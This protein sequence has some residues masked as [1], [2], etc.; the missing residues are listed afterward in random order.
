MIKWYCKRRFLNQYFCQITLLISLSLLLLGC[1]VRNNLQT[2]RALAIEF[3]G[4]MIAPPPIGLGYEIKAIIAESN[5][6]RVNP[7][8]DQMLSL[9]PAEIIDVVKS[10]PRGFFR[11]QEYARWEYFIG[12]IDRALVFSDAAIQNS[13]GFYTRSECLFDQVIF[14]AASGDYFAA[15]AALQ[16]AEETIQA[17]LLH[18]PPFDEKFTIRRSYL[19]ALSKAS[20]Q[21][22]QG[23]MKQAEK[24]YFEA[25]EHLTQLRQVKTV[26][27]P[28]IF[29]FF[30]RSDHLVAHIHIGIAN[31]L[32]WQGRL[33]EA[34]IW[35]R[36]SIVYHGR[37]MLP[38]IFITLSRIF[39][40]Q[41]QFE[42]SETLALSA[43]DMFQNNFPGL[44]CVP[45]DSLAR[46][47]SRG[48]LA[49]T[50]L[51]QGRYAEALAQFELI[52]ME[53]ATN[54]ETFE[55]IFGGNL[56]WGL[57]LLMSGQVDA[58]KAQLQR[59][60]E[61]A[62]YRFGP[63]DYA[64]MEARA[65]LAVA[66]AAAGDTGNARAA[67]DT[68]FNRLVSSQGDQPAA[69]VGYFSRQRRLEIIAEGYIA[70]LTRDNDSESAAKAFAI[71]GRCLSRSVGTTLAATSARSASED[72][73]LTG[74]I[75]Q[76]QDLDMAL[77]A[78]RSRIAE[79]MNLKSGTGKTDRLQKIL[80]ELK[81]RGGAL[82]RAIA[83]LDQEIR[84][85]F[86]EYSQMVRP[87]TANIEHIRKVMR[88][89]EAFV[90]VFTGENATF[91]WS[92]QK[93]SPVRFAKVWIGARELNRYVYD[94]RK[95][96]DPGS[97]ARVK[98]I[99]VFDTT[100]ANRLFDLLLAPV[101][102][103][104]EKSKILLVVANA[105][106]DRLPLSVLV[107]DSTAPESRNNRL[108]LSDYQRIPWLIRTH[109]VATLPSVG[110]IV[111]LR[112]RPSLKSRK[113]T[114]AG[115]GDPWFSRDQKT[116]S[117]KTTSS[118]A[119][120]GFH[121][122]SVPKRHDVDVISASLPMLPRL[123]ETADEVREIAVSLGA[124][125]EKDVFSGPAA[126]EAQIKTMDLSDRRILVFATHGLMPGD[127]DGLHQPAL[128]MS[129]PAYS[130]DNDSDGL[131]TMGEI[132]WLNLNAD[133][134]V[135]SACNTASPNG[136]G[137]EAM[138]GLGQA[139]FYAG[140]RSMLVTNWPVETNSAKTLTTALFQRL[141][142]HP[143]IH[144]AKALQMSQTALID[145]PG[146]G[147]Y[148]Y[149]HPLFWAP[150]TFVG[151]GNY[152]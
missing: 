109:A 138:S 131:L 136:R 30:S 62:A 37:F 2:A 85:Q 63:Y 134:V 43:L 143:A 142:N 46:A 53:M 10:G 66:L 97:I 76:R 14:D 58:S 108:L 119:Q 32:L 68:F 145:G 44:S 121:L 54:P 48:A 104:W 51:A 23:E 78:N 148:S 33:L 55:R 45:V 98:D 22:S 38:R 103:G 150:Y 149:A 12:N 71:A 129:H 75:R 152:R 74:T 135:L 107:T 139:F 18:G 39:Y 132:M 95:A 70:L 114:Y 8:C 141:G 27:S 123:P 28:S 64:A 24:L 69:I 20:I 79:L 96:V 93:K 124:D 49:R 15:K 47:L 87:Q 83:T 77:A 112:E 31:A 84:H 73:R 16:K 19:H 34:E 122:R 88:P 115:F 17:G 118:I 91:V 81:A 40:E 60:S 26:K 110:S 11:L 130:G 36:K 9:S 42:K 52:K 117:P 82:K 128:A 147:K 125:V 89:D 13:R 72:P 140:A 94:L 116:G 101:R 120:M 106:I 105:P 61:K 137:K 35:A 92:F 56:D 146:T 41:G 59:A 29:D 100:L 50:Y 80:G 151:D 144:R 127:I 21:F 65:L 133:W 102:E 1:Q 126:S 113:L 99:P 111:N 6:R 90:L 4:Q 3:Q 5:K 25:L 86:P 67:L 57:A 7:T